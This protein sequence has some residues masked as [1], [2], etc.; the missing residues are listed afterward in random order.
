MAT[1]LVSHNKQFKL[2][3]PSSIIFSRKRD[4]KRLARRH[5]EIKKKKKSEIIKL[6]KGVTGPPDL[7]GQQVQF[8]QTVTKLVDPQAQVQTTTSNPPE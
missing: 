1:Q 2:E 7:V 6:D 4:P 5:D 3:F 8:H